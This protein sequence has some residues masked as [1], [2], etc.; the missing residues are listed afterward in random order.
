MPQA[1]VFKDLRLDASYNVFCGVILARIAK[2]PLF[3]SVIPKGIY[4]SHIFDQ[5]LFLMVDS[6]SV[7]NRRCD[8]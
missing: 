4:I 5:L 6:D 3:E 2:Q 7:E 8:F 1:L